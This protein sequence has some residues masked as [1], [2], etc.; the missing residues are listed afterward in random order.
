MKDTNQNMVI[1][2]K[3]NVRNDLYKTKGQTMN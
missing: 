3:F 1:N 2:I